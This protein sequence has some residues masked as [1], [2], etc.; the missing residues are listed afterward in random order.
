MLV[1]NDDVL[2]DIRFSRYDRLNEREAFL[3]HGTKQKN[4]VFR[5]PDALK[6]F[7]VLSAFVA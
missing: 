5:G 6:T 1:S 3:R 4:E 2:L 7:H